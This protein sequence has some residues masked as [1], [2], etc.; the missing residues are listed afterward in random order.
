MN[1]AA[2]MCTTRIA[3]QL[4]ASAKRNMLRPCRSS[5]RPLRVTAFGKRKKAMSEADLYVTVAPPKPATPPSQT[6]FIATILPK[7]VLAMAA[8]WLFKK[9]K[10]H[11]KRQ[12]Y[13]KMTPAQKEAM[14]LEFVAN[15][16]PEEFEELS[17]EQISAARRRRQ[18]MLAKEGES[19][20]I[21]RLWEGIDLPSNHPFLTQQKM[22]AAEEEETK[23]RFKARRGGMS[24]DDMKQLMAVM[25]QAEEMER[26]APKN[27]KNP[28]MQ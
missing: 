5:R 3:S 24:S 22:T 23:A 6:S 1:T 8:L 17:N 14:F 26:N 27:D 7:I 9:F 11:R 16:A 10:Q 13:L 28:F 21:D 19:G 12:A 4:D 20:N 18:K 2:R 25:A 15:S